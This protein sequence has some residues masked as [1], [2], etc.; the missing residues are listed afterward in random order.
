MKTIVQNRS[1]LIA[2]D[3]DSFLPEEDAELRWLCEQA[4]QAVHMKS[5]W[6]ATVERAVDG[7][8]G[9]HLGTTL[10][11][12]EARVDAM[13]RAGTILGWLEAIAPAHC[14]VLVAAYR[15]PERPLPAHYALKLGRLAGVVARLASV[16][17]GFERALAQRRTV[18]KSP[19]DWLDE[20]IVR[21]DEERANVA[22]REAFGVYARALAAYRAARGNRPSLAPEAS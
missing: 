10:G 21:G 6:P 18:A 2:F 22:R 5:L 13:H 14:D 1:H 20:Q 3:I 7:R 9:A 15:P 11:E 19:V 12:E 4:E 16:R 17:E 8:G